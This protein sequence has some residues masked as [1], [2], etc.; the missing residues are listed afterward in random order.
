VAAHC[1]G[2]N[3]ACTPGKA[4]EPLEDLTACA[5][6]PA[7]TSGRCRCTT[8]AECPRSQHCRNEP[9]GMNRCSSADA[10]ECTPY[11]RV[12]VQSGCPNFCQYN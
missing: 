2:C 6:R 4:C 9:A 8:S 5:M 1:G 10:S 7:G 3:S 12:T 11:S